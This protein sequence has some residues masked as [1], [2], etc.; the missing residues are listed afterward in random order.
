MLKD[1][2]QRGTAVVMLPN[3]ACSFL[4]S[5]QRQR[6]GIGEVIFLVIVTAYCTILLLSYKVSQLRTHRFAVYQEI[7]RC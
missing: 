2:S 5:L 7:Q 4:I 1:L 6:I 3:P